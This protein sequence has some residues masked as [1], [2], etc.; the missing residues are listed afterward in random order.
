VLAEKYAPDEIL[1]HETFF[2]ELGN[3]KYCQPA[4]PDHF[5]GIPQI[6]NTSTTRSMI[7]KHIAEKQGNSYRYVSAH[8]ILRHEL[9]PLIHGAVPG[10]NASNSVLTVL[11]R[12]CAENNNTLIRVKI[13]ELPGSKTVSM[14][15]MARKPIPRKTPSPRISQPFLQPSYIPY[16][17][18]SFSS[19]STDPGPECQGSS[20]SSSEV[21]SGLIDDPVMTPEQQL[22]TRHELLLESFSQDFLT[23]IIDHASVTVSLSYTYDG[24]TYHVSVKDFD[25]DFFNGECLFRDKTESVIQVFEHFRRR[26]EEKQN[27]NIPGSLTKRL[28]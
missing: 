7:L 3:Y 12:M 24:V 22:P 21:S 9:I 19:C 8:N 14:K 11:Q 5:K 17:Q 4:I 28:R 25:Y 27:S 16:A 6:K 13:P 10:V 15:G 20:C 26:K 1:P 23:E 18:E 2:D